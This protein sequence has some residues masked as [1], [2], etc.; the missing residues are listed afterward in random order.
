MPRFALYYAPQNGSSLAEAAASWFGRDGDRL[1][2]EQLVPEELS[3]QQFR[4]A[5]SVPFHYGFHGTLKPPFHLAEIFSGQQLL[6]ALEQ[7][8]KAKTI[9]S[10]KRLEL[11]W[12]GNFLCLKPVEPS[13]RLNRLARQT[14]IEFDQF[15][16]PM[17]DAELE[18]RRN[19][20]LSPEQ[21]NY[22]LQWGYPYIMN[23][24][25]FHLTLSSDVTQQQEREL[26]EKEARRHFSDPL[27]Q[28][29]PVEGISLF[30]EEEGNPMKQLQFFPF[31]VHQCLATIFG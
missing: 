23:E 24:F 15:R 7:F 12:I 4:K 17:S 27:L 16:A 28:E 29:V 6:E 31:K 3:Q 25:R 14:V 13:A 11:A 5:T 9:F 8:C 21:D 20:E 1:D 19:K 22:L 30:V 26:L 18:K 10:I 2:L